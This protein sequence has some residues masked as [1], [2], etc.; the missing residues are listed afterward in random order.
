VDLWLIE[1]IDKSLC[2]GRLE[3][4]QVS[5]IIG[6]YCQPPKSKSDAALHQPYD[7]ALSPSLTFQTDGGQP[8][9]QFPVQQ[10]AMPLK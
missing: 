8:D 5:E 9:W 3:G 2:G 6:Q 4:L 7:T 1:D 10:Q